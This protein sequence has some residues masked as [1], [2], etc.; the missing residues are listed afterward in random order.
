M[1][2]KDVNEFAISVGIDRSKLVH[3]LQFLS[4]GIDMSAAS[5]TSML[6]HFSLPL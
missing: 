2:P 4:D 6:F 1:H 5:N 3:L